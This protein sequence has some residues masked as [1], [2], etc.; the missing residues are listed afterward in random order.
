MAVAANYMFRF[1]H[2]GVNS[3]SSVICKFPYNGCSLAPDSIHNV[4]TIYYYKD[5]EFE[6]KLGMTYNS[7]LDNRY[8]SVDVNQLLLG[9]EECNPYL[10]ASLFR[11]TRNTYIISEAKNDEEQITVYTAL[12]NDKSVS[13]LR[14]TRGSETITYTFNY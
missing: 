4:D 3:S 11:Y 5:G 8:Q 7:A 12:N 13:A 6:R 14:V 1:G 9:V 2:Y 10:L